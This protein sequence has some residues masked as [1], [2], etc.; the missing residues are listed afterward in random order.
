MYGLA[1][2]RPTQY[3]TFL[4]KALG[5]FHTPSKSGFLLMT[6]RHIRQLTLTCS[7]YFH[8][9]V[10]CI[11]CLCFW[12]VWMSIED[13]CICAVYDMCACVLVF[14][15]MSAGVNVLWHVC[16]GQ[17]RLLVLAFHLDCKRVSWL[18]A[19]V[20]ARLSGPRAP[21]EAV[22]CFHLSL[23]PC[24]STPSNVASGD[25]SQSQLLLPMTKTYSL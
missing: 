1:K 25:I 13:V 18:F 4:M 3:N 9:Y 20:N 21:G 19:H 15:C 12:H 23:L 7:F 8:L 17:P 11:T 22:S 2:P 24:A 5:A 14:V 6:S 10:L 16:E